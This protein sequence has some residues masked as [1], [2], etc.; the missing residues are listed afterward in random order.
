MT[1]A[2]R[3]ESI[4]LDRDGATNLHRQL[5]GQLRKLIEN[6]AVFGKVVICP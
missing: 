6:R 1:S 2:F 5:Y 4:I 3:L